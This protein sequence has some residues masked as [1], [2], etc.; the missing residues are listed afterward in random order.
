MKDFFENQATMMRSSL[1]EAREFLEEQFARASCAI[2]RVT[3]QEQLEY[4]I[5]WGCPFYGGQHRWS[6]E[7]QL[8]WFREFIVDM[9]TTTLN[10]LLLRACRLNRDH[11][12]P[13]IIH[14]GAEVNGAHARF[15]LSGTMPL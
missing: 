7:R 2:K 12:I 3:A 1:E 15:D 5:N 11:L 8:N 13:L 14:Q 6:R 4:I 9:N 10:I